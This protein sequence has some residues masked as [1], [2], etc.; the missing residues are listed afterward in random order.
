M[1]VAWTFLESF[2]TLILLM[3]RIWRAPNNA[4]TWQMAFNSAF[5]GL[6]VKLYY[7]CMYQKDNCE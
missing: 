5:K 3:R 1:Y 6:N 2:L 7:D 4:S